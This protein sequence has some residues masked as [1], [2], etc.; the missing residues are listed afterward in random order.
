MN[1]IHK[2]T[3]LF[4]FGYWMK[5]REVLQSVSNSCA[6][7]LLSMVI[8]SF[9][10]R[11]SFRLLFTW[12]TCSSGFSMVRV[13][14][15]G[16]EPRTSSYSITAES[17]R[18]YGIRSNETNS[19][20]NK[21]SELFTLYESLYKKILKNR[22]MSCVI[23]QKKLYWKICLFKPV[24]FFWNFLFTF[25]K[26]NIEKIRTGKLLQKFHFLKPVYST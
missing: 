15:W 2:I 21:I 20:L 25:S 9:N 24:S 26:K 23:S 13:R 18:R 17:A 11:S 4:P 5:K 10:F 7:N 14:R 19:A 6:V 22:E 8:Q 1:C 16:S 12:T 3:Q